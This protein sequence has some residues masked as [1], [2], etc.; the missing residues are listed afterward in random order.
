MEREAASLLPPA[1]S[2]AISQINH[3][4]PWH[5]AVCMFL[6]GAKLITNDDE[7]KLKIN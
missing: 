2:V 6:S 7:G 5:K 4:M 1:A 3:K